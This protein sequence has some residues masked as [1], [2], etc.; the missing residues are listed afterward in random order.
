MLSPKAK[1]C[2]LLCTDV[3]A[4]GLDFPAV[5]T[6]IQYDPA[7]DPAEYVHRVGRTAR[8]GQQ[9]EALLFLMHSEMPYLDLLE[10]RGMQLQQETAEAVLRC[11][12]ALLSTNDSAA[13]GSVH[14]LAKKLRQEASTAAGEQQGAGSSK[15]SRGSRQGAA[16]DGG[17][18][19]AQ[20]EGQAAG[21]MLQR[22][23]LLGISGDDELKQLALNAFRCGAVVCSGAPGDS[24]PTSLQSAEF[25]G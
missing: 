18:S 15:G 17:L 11:L 25:A 5:S 23:L 20:A 19:A 1:S 2:V 16:A 7:G 12:P 3:A 10:Q 21:L 22:Q 9:G 4:R 8:M 13:A 6:I 14:R 24:R